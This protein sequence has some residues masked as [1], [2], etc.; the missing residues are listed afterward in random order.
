MCWSP[1]L[2]APCE[3]VLVEQE[4]CYPH[5]VTWSFLEWLHA[6]DASVPR[7]ESVK[8]GVLRDEM[9]GTEGIYCQESC[10]LR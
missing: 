5:R 3:S 1:H 4:V 2:N 6:V 7:Y 8:L 9:L 10:F